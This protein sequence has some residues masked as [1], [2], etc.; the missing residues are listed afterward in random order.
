MPSILILYLQLSNHGFKVKR[1]SKN[2]QLI[3][4]L[5]YVSIIEPSHN[6]LI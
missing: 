2:A 3:E 6:S 5:L 4:I 1:P